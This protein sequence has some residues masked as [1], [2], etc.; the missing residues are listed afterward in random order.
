MNRLLGRV[1]SR[2]DARALR[3]AKYV[4]PAAI[5]KAP[6]ASDWTHA[7]RSWGMY[8]NDV[9]GDC[10]C[11]AMAHMFTAQAANAD[12][13]APE[14]PDV[15]VVTLYQ[16]AS[17]YD[18]DRPG[19]DRG[20]QMVDV[21]RLMQ[22]RGLAGIKIGAYAALTPQSRAEIEMAV[23]LTGCAYVGVDL[24][25]AAQ[26]Q[27]VWDVA[28]PGK[29]DDRYRPGSW[30]GHAMAL[31]GYDRSHVTF[32]SWGQVRIATVEWLMTYASEAWAIVD[33]LWLREDGLTPSGFDAER[34]RADL[35]SIQR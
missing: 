30:G 24:P 20:A 18:P 15:E 17:G 4:D 32:V 27:T 31:L 19:S 22:R 7:V 13:P 10:T 14:I 5:D 12:R 2:R 16:C 33:D 3:F 1:P 8:R 35:A 23:N 9:V 34:L 21:L 25:L 28:S 11:A 29:Y 6:P 26:D